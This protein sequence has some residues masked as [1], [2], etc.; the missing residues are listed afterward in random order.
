MPA[1]LAL[2]GKALA[3]MQQTASELDPELQ[4]LEVVGAFLRRRALAAA[5]RHADPQVMLY[6]LQKLRLRA[7]RLLVGAER[8]VG[9]RPGGGLQIELRGA[10]ELERTIRSGALLVALSIVA[11]AL[12]VAL[13][14]LLAG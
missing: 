7:G 2:A 9:A 13:A 12:I 4:P 11:A 5:L 6:E 8:A 1:S 3:Q 14:I 10:R